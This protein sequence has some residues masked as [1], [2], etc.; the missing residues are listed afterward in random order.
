MTAYLDMAAVAHMLG[1]DPR[2]VSRYRVRDPTF[3]PPDITLG[4]SP[5]WHPHTIKAWQASRPGRGA[6][7]GRP[8]KKSPQP[9]SNGPT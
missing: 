6:G 8:R 9:A 4:R 7:G 5:G 2:S 1:V 3:P